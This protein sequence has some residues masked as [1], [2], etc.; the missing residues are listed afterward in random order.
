MLSVLLG[1]VAAAAYGAADFCGGLATKR[2]ATLAVACVGQG[3]GLVILVPLAFFVPAHLAVSDVLLGLGAG[4]CGGVGIALLYHALAIGTMGVVS[5]VTAVIAAALPVAVGF[6]RGE[7]LHGTQIAGIVVALVA[8]VLISASTEES[9]ER[10]IATAGL[11]E[12]IASGVLLGGFLAIIAFVRADAGLTALI[13]A[14][15]SAVLAIAAVALAARVDL[16]PPRSVLALVAGS[17]LLD[18]SA[19][20][21]YVAAA[22]FGGLSVAAVLTS[23]YPAATVV[24]ARVVL[25]E[26]LR[27]WQFAGML[28]ALG[29]VALIA[30]GR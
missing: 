16:R 29:G 2:A 9:G 8:I 4:V 30:F 7:R 1:L 11:R 25:R 21:L 24:L 3:A 10:E 15:I 5:P 23:L 14:R 6:V 13:A 28:L 20:V 22:R 18:G 17:G 12:A 26:R 19:L 27:T